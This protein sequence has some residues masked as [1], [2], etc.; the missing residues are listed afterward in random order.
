MLYKTSGMQI[1]PLKCSFY[2]KDT[3]RKDEK[4]IVAFNDKVWFIFIMIGSYFFNIKTCINSHQQ[5][6][7]E[8]FVSLIPWFTKLYNMISFFKEL[9]TRNEPLSYTEVVS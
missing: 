6:T 1:G 9:K 4:R 7:N 8:N 3:L 2:Y 5:R